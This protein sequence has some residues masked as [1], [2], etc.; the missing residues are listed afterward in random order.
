MLPTL[1][2]HIYAMS[3][4]TAALADALAAHLKIIHYETSWQ[5]EAMAGLCTA[6]LASRKG[7]PCPRCFAGL[8]DGGD[9][10]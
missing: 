7:Q 2:E 10:K 5:G 6:F 9:W 8:D 4:S 1:D 3:E